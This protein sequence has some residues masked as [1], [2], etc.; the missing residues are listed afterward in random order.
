MNQEESDFVDI[1]NNKT[2][3][4]LGEKVLKR[5]EKTVNGKRRVIFL[6]KRETMNVGSFE[7]ARTRLSIMYNLK[8]RSSVVL[9]YDD[10]KETKKNLREIDYLIEDIKSLLD[11][12]LIEHKTNSET[13]EDI[14]FFF[15]DNKE[16]IQ[17]ENKSI[18]LREVESMFKK[19]FTNESHLKGI[20]VFLI[21]KIQKEVN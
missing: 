11:S 15:Y 10:H 18:L 16:R 5:I 8:G 6:G 12:I 7:E 4:R 1:V 17:L 3:E 19:Y 9:K 13:R 21:Q 20:H 14:N 2:M